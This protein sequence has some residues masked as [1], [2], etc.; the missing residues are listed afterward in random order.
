MRQTLLQLQS[1]ELSN[2]RC[3]KGIFRLVTGQN[4]TVATIPPGQDA[5]QIALRKSYGHSLKTLN[6]Y[7]AR[8]DHGEY[9]AVFRLLADGQRENCL[10]IAEL[11]ALTEV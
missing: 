9:G 5:T 4:L 11:A 2:A 8:A 6:A 7:E 10:K 3:L 1:R